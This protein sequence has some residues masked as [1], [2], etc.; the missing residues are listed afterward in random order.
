MS[1]NDQRQRAM[2]KS[3]VRFVQIFHSMINTPARKSLGPKE[4]SL[5]LAL[6][7]RYNGTN[8]GRIAF[9]ARD[10]VGVLNV[11]T[12][13]ANRAFRCLKD[14]GLIKEGRH[15]HFSSLG[16]KATE[17]RLTEERDDRTGKP[18]TRDYLSWDLKKQIAVSPETQGV[19]DG[20]RCGIHIPQDSAFSITDGPQPAIRNGLASHLRHTYTSS[21]RQG[22][23]EGE[24]RQPPKQAGGSPPV[25]ANDNSGRKSSVPSSRRSEPELWPK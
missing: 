11:S 3:N 20:E 19:A 13:S 15:G 24:K 14:R 4:V 10:A 25:S 22:E 21:H 23:A 12:G 8:N 7:V 9:S 16:S 2:G 18:P 1:T 17:W 6:K 5:Y